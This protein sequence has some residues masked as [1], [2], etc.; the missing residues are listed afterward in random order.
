M[1]SLQQ[2]TQAQIEKTRQAKPEFMDRIDELMVQATQFKQGGQAIAVGQRAPD[3]ELPNSNGDPTK[4]SGLLRRG[5]VVLMFYRG[6]WCPYCNLQLRAMQTRLSEIHALG[7]ELVA[8]SPQVPEQSLSMIEK[9]ELEFPVLSDQDARVAA[10]FGVAWQVPELILDHMRKDRGLDLAQINNGNAAVLP[11]P[12]T[13]VLSADGVVIWRYVNVDYRS[14]AE[15]DDVIMA[16]K[17]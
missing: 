4:L 9:A 16:L 3:F 7:A 11:I 2:Q 12:A 13:F 17:N 6:G 1:T 8:I 10:Q 15:P 5:P 14:R